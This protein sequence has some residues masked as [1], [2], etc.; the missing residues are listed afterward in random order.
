MLAVVLMVC[1]LAGYGEAAV[2]LQR[3][4]KLQPES[5]PFASHVRSHALVSLVQKGLLYHEI[6]QAIDQACHADSRQLL[7]AERAN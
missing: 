5:L 3:D 6:E 1:V 7:R 2:R 4:W